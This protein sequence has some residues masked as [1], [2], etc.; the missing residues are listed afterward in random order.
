MS[1][2]DRINQL[3]TENN[4]LKSRVA[5]LEQQVAE[6]SQRPR[7]DLS[8]VAGREASVIARLKAQGLA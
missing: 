3:I 2:N 7:F 1:L 8:T 5:E 6:L 4:Q